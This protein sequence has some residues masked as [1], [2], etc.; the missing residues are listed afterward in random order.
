MATTDTAAQKQTGKDALEKALRSI[1][2][3]KIKE[4]TPI[5]LG[6]GVSFDKIQQRTAQ[7]DKAFAE[8]RLDDVQSLLKGQQPGILGKLGG[9]LKGANVSFGKQPDPL[10]Q[11]IRGMQ[12]QQTQQGQVQQQQ[13]QALIAQLLGGGGI[14]QQAQGATAQASQTQGASNLGVTGISA[15]PSGQTVTLGQ[16]PGSKSK[17]A[18]LQKR[19]QEADKRLQGAEFTSDDFATFAKRFQLSQAELEKT[20]GKEIGQAG[21]AAVG[22]RQIAKFSSHFGGIPETTA[23]RD[24]I[25]SFATPLA[26]SA[27]EDRLT[28]EDINRF[29]KLLGDT[30]ANSSGVNAR[31]MRD[32]LLQ[33]RDKGADV[34]TIISTF[35]RASGILGDAADLFNSFEGDVQ[36]AGK[37]LDKSSASDQA[38]AFLKG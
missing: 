24:S 5:A 30:L 2:D 7:F 9:L 10:L 11:A 13:N 32:L 26:K 34:S 21:V 28:N 1:V 16:T 36:K 33:F 3:K 29:T 4:D 27:G 18:I 19:D 14:P 22:L 17:M 38:D 8:G 12:L 35:K 25:Q 31:K 6:Q 20:F 15:G 37:S 23:F